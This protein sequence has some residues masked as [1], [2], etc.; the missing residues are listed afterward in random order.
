MSSLSVN[1]I[2]WL[3][4]IPSS[5]LVCKQKRSYKK[6][7]VHYLPIW[8]GIVLASLLVGLRWDNGGDYA[9]YFSIISDSLK[10]NYELERLE[11]IPR[12][13]MVLIHYFHLP[14]YL[15]FIL[16]AFFQLVFM[17]LLGHRINY[18]LL[19]WI[20]IL[21]FYC[22]F[23]LSL[24]IIRQLVALTIVS[25]AYTFIKPKDILHYLLLIVLAYGFHRTSL[26]CIPLY[27]VAPRLNF[28][29]IGAQLVIVTVFLIVG[30]RPVELLWS[31]V[32]VDITTFRYAGY[33]GREYEYGTNS[34]LGVLFNYIRYFIIILYSNKLKRKYEEY[35]FSVFYSILFVHICLYYAVKDDLPLSRAMMYFSVAE[36]L[37]TCFLLHY[38]SRSKKN[39]DKI[40]L[41][42]VCVI[43]VLTM[44]Y[45]AYTG[46]DWQFVWAVQI[47]YIQ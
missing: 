8:I 3:L 36:I 41:V 5:V 17:F 37:V 19:P 43:I 10:D 16:M 34:G 21:Y 46:P 7:S 23:P 39:L 38:L 33:L 31:L 32:P 9:N 6:G 26:L 28:C 12:Y 29:N 22:L 25:Y 11:F 14:F 2:L 47:P 40:S 13:L 27:W 18:R 24:I 45:T 20:F 4:L 15:W 42:T 44:C 35:G 1:I 30:N